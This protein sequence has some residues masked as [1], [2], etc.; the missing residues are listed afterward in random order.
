MTSARSI[1]PEADLLDV[2][3]R[4]FVNLHE[5]AAARAGKPRWADKNPENVLYNSQ[6]QQLLG[7]QWLMIHVARNPLD[8]LASIKEI[9]FPLAI[10]AQLHERIQF[11]RRYIKAGLDFGKEHPDRY[12]RV[13]YEQLVLSPQA[14]LTRM[15]QWLGETFEPGQLRFNA[16]PQEG[17]LEDPKIANTS[18]IHA[19]SNGRWQVVLSHQEAQAVWR[20]THDLWALIDPDGHYDEVIRISSLLE[21]K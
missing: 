4:A 16:F 14:T 15:M 20:E 9:K 18:E 10:P 5:R 3:G 13:L 7:D 17:G 11:Y 19:A 2:L 12:H 6:W 1:L 21:S 8:T